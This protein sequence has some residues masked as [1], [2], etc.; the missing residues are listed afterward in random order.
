MKQ[1]KKHNINH[2]TTEANLHKQNP[3]KGVIRELRCKWYRVMVQKQVSPR[4]WDYGMKWCANIMSLT[5]TSAGYING[6]IPLSRVTGETSDISQFLDFGFYDY[7]WYKDNAGLGPQLPGRWL[8]VADSHG[9]L[10]CYHVIKQNGEI[11]QRSSVQRVTQLELQTNEY[12]TLFTTF[13]SNIKQRLNIKD[14]AYNEAKPNPEDWANIIE[15]DPDFNE[16]FNKVFSDTNIP[17]ADDHTPEVLEDTYMNMELALPRDGEGP[18]YAKVTKRPRD[19]K[20]I[21]IRTAHN[22]PLLDTCIYEIEYVDGHKASLAA[23]NIAINMFAQVDAKGNRHVLFD[24]IVDHRT[25][26]TEVK[27]DNAF[28]TSTKAGCRCKETTK[29]WELL[30]QWKDGSTTWEKLKDIKKCYPVQVSEYSVQSKISNKPV[31]A[32]WVPHVLKKY[33]QIIAKV[34]SKYWTRTHK[35]GI[36]IPKSVKEAKILDEQNGNTLWRE[37]IL[38]KKGKVQIAFKLFKVKRKIF[39]HVIKKKND[40]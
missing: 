10:M 31:Y 15:L 1:I 9:N 35:F 19:A 39:H 6:C 25:D 17:E 30:V 2:H 14:H 16:E 20:G 28:I 11:V 36:K 13:D 26:G 4:L 29:G 32:W 7:V 5:H 37:A 34:K 22:N 12:K 27:I 23:N 40:T 18:E 24:E 3:A 33:Q 21:P 38:K 8:G